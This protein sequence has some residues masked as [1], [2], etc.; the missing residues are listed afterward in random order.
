MKH[1][2]RR[3]CKIPALCACLL[4]GVLAAGCGGGTA[5][6]ESAADTTAA[7]TE[8]ENEMNAKNVVISRAGD[9]PG[10]TLV[11][12]TGADEN[13]R[14]NILLIR[15]TVRALGGG[16][17]PMADELFANKESDREIVVGGKKR[18]EAAALAA[19]LSDGE[20]AI[21]VVRDPASGTIRV[22]LAYEG[23]FARMA[24]IDRFVSDCL[25]CAENGDVTVPADLDL[26]GRC[27]E[28]DVMITSSI[29]SLRDPFVLLG[30]D[31]TYYAYGTGWVYYKNTSGSLSGPWAGPYN[32][33]Q[34]PADAGADFW[35]PEVH[36][37][38]GKYYMFTTYRSK[39][40]GHRGCTVLRTDTPEGPFVQISDGHVTPKDWDAIDGTFFLDAHGQPWMVF[41]HEW[42]ST[43]NG[44]GRMAAAKL[45]DDLSRFV[46]EPV[47]LFDAKSP[48]WAKNNVTDGCFLWRLSDGGLMMLWSNWDVRGYCVGVAFSENGEVDGP[49]KQTSR[50]LYSAGLTGGYDGGHGMIFADRDGQLYLALHSPNSATADR[51]CVPVFLPVREFAGTLVW[52]VWNQVR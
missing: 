33:V 44:V 5:P 9:V 19:T 3:S 43:P 52:D 20:Y 1:T 39:A 49:W 37:Y 18:P 41:V 47:E 13:V 28:A 21:R 27:T 22:V 24:A 32:C 45:S 48:S 34:T 17:M 15:D 36:R 50:R 14:L 51:G 31:G 35:A 8:E 38:N 42:T 7:E 16:E 30:D 6:D 10:F 40:T 12:D 29:P 11:F 4:A 46:S 26:R 25:V 2:P 23:A